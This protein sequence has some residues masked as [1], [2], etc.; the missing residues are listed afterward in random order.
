MPRPDHQFDFAACF[1]QLS[2][3]AHRVADET[4]AARTILSICASANARRVALAGLPAS[5]ETAIEAGCDGLELLKPPYAADTLP[6]AIDTAD[7]GVTGI[8]FAIA[9]S[10]T[11]V[12]VTTDDAVR[13]V[14]SLPRTYI[15]VLRAEDIVDKFADGAARIRQ[16]VQRYEKNLVISFISGPSRTGDIELKLTLG[17]HGPEAAHAVI[18]G[19]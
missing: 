7:V 19:S 15:G 18:I 6:D 9:Q 8:E 2:G 13:L 11:L 14:S 16:T 12:E 5:L 3:Q 17:V 4:E 10:G 1:A